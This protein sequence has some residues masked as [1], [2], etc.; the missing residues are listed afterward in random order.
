MP[1]KPKKPCGFPG[2]PAL[3][4]N[5]YCDEHAK[6]Y[7]NERASAAE[8]GYDGRW[9]KARARFLK[10]NP[11]CVSCQLENKLVK[12]TVVD[13]VIPHR[14]DEKLFWDESNWQALCKKC[15]DRKTRTKDQHK[16]YKY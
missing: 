10:V 11:L 7:V 16:E 6:F 4:D 5:K 14:G 13:H 9:R 2:C 12:A 8:R 15:H 3:T 1:K